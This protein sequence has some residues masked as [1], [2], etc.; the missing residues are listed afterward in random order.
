MSEKKFYVYKWFNTSTGEVFYIGKGCGKRFQVTKKRNQKFL[1]YISENPVSSEIIESNL[2][3]EESFQKEKEWYD[4][5]KSLNQCS[6]NLMEPGTGGLSFVWTEE[7][8]TYWSKNNPMKKEE[9]RQRMKE[10]NPMKNP[11]TALKNGA[12]H[13]RAVIIGD[14]TFDSLKEAGLFFNV[15]PVTIGSWCK[16]GISSKGEK[17]SYADGKGAKKCKNK[18]IPVLIDDVYYPSIADAAAHLDVSASAIKLS[19]K[20]NKPTKNHICKYAN[21]QPSQ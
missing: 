10:N 17:C 21:Q 3:E 15:S 20:N 2:T 7:M 9:Q 5:Y 8:K 13:K 4:Y 14:K 16:N 19:L 18:G 12:A 6:C 11:E 1:D